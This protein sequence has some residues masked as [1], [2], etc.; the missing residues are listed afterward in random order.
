MVM[1]KEEKKRKIGSFQCRLQDLLEYLFLKKV[2][3][4]EAKRK[5]SF[6]LSF[7]WQLNSEKVV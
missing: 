2:G 3:E 5:P 4:K 7:A 6:R 1:V